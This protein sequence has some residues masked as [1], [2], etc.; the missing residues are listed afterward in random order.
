MISAFPI[1]K[2]LGIF[3][4]LSRLAALAAPSILIAPTFGAP[5]APP[6]VEPKIEWEVYNRFRYY[7]DAEIFRRYLDQARQTANK[8]PENWILNTEHFLQEKYDRDGW[9]AANIRN[10]DDLCFN[11]KTRDYG[12][13]KD[14]VNPKSH[15]ILVGVNGIQGVDGAKCE[16][17]LLTNAGAAPQEQA[18]GACTGVKIDAPYE[19]GENTRISVTVSSASGP[20]PPISPVPVDVR[21]FLIV[22]M[23]DSFGAGVGNPDKPA[24]IDSRHSEIVDYGNRVWKSNV[25]SEGRDRDYLPTRPGARKG[26]PKDRQDF[27]DAAG[28]WLDMPCF[29]SQYGPQFRAALHLGV[30]MPHAA[31]TYLDYSCD[32]ARVLEGL[33]SRKKLD[34]SFG[35]NQTTTPAQLEQVTKTVCAEQNTKFDVKVKLSPYLPSYCLGD[36]LASEQK[37]ICEFNNEKYQDDPDITNAPIVLEGCASGGSQRQIDYIFLSIGG[38]DIGFAPLVADA[39]SRQDTIDLDFIGKMEQRIGISETWHVALDRLKY[40]PAKYYHLSRAFEALLPIRGGDQTRVFLMGYPMP[41]GYPQGDDKYD[42]CGVNHE[43]KVDQTSANY[44]DESMDGVNF[45]GGFTDDDKPEKA[46]HVHDAVCALNRERM[47]WTSGN[48]DDQSYEVKERPDEKSWL[49][50]GVCKDEIS[51]DGTTN[52]SPFPDG[53]KLQWRYITN[54]ID[55]SWA[56]GFCARVGNDECGNDPYSADCVADALTMPGFQKGENGPTSPYDVAKYRPYAERARWFRTFN[57]AYLTTNWQDPSK[58]INDLDN[59]IDAFTTS[60]IHPTA[61]GY[62]AMADSLFRAIRA[63]LCV[64][65]ELDDSANSVVDLK[66]CAAPGHK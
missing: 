40:L 39:A 6:K 62:A 31:V 60:A 18:N 48:I 64:R 45:L 33:L 21:D 12:N 2:E 49:L 28:A 58:D 4:R 3:A 43:K 13:C 24:Q 34:P 1:F 36:K 16:W 26:N 19:P 29:R 22:G 66:A 42:I 37:V 54:F 41:E 27:N 35:V 44:A 57:D 56:H 59:A 10:T 65:G 51:L 15:A 32:G 46:L 20:L 55:K 38:N 30:A 61:E 23:G 5:A 25:D 52:L 47:Y 50:G 8:D 14:Y 9:A 7:K 17:T 53:K 63:D 11:R